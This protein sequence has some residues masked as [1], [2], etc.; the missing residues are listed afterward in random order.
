MAGAITI[1]AT[2]KTTEQASK[3]EKVEGHLDHLEAE[4]D[5]A[6]QLYASITG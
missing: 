1:T 5:A 4:I 3:S 2:L 6:M